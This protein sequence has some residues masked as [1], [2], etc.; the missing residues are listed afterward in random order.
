MPVYVQFVTLFITYQFIIMAAW[1]LPGLGVK[2]GPSSFFLVI[3]R[4]CFVLFCL[5]FFFFFGW[6]LLISLCVS[7]IIHHHVTLRVREI[8]W[9]RLV[10]SFSFFFFF[11][12]TRSVLF[13][14]DGRMKPERSSFFFCTRSM[15]VG[16]E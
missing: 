5:V 7:I 1:T 9:A 16:W 3:D 13:S 2:F 14:W 12:E 8:H 11:L 6:V 10:F 4:I 15:T